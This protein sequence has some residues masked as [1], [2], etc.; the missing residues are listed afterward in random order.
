MATQQIP[1]IVDTREQRPWSFQ[2]EEFAVIKR[3]LP[4]GD[5]SIVGLENRVAI[6]RKSL[7]DFVQTVISEWLRFRKE[8][9]RLGGYDFAA[10]VVECNIKDIFDHA[11]DSTAQPASVLARAAE[12]TIDHAIPVTFAGDHLLAGQFAAR[13]LKLAWKRWGSNANA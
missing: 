7:G 13:M 9:N 10:V 8:L 3:G 5:Y 4:A 11:Y 2:P 12:I 1:I 6:E